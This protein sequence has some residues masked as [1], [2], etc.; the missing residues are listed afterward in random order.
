MDSEILAELSLKP[1]VSRP[2]E[3]RLNLDTIESQGVVD[4]RSSKTKSFLTDFRG[5][6][7]AVCLA[8][9]NG[10]GEWY[11]DLKRATPRPFT[12]MP[13]IGANDRGVAPKAE[14]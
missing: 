4:D 10:L 5:E 2:G 3:D 11:I 7:P 9:P 12:R 6:A 14:G 13:F 8:Q 1:S